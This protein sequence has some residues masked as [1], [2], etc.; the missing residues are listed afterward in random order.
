MTHVD[1]HHRIQQPPSW[2]M[3][4]LV[5]FSLA[6][7]AIGAYQ[8]WHYVKAPRGEGFR[9]LPLFA[10][11]AINALVGIAATVWAWSL[12]QGQG[13]S[14]EIP[15]LKLLILAVGGVL[16]LS[17]FVCLG[18]LYVGT[19]SFNDGPWSTLVLKGREAWKQWT[20]WQPVV[21]AVA[22]L[23]VMFMSLLAV[24]SEERTNATLRR[25]IYGY[26]AA[27]TG[28]L[29]L[30][31]L[32]V[33]CVMVHFYGVYKGKP[34]FDWTE[35]HIYSIS[36]DTRRLL[37]GVKNPVKI[38]I[39]FP[40]ESPTR[41]D[42]EML[43]SSFKRENPSRIEVESLSPTDLQDLEKLVALFQKY[44]IPFEDPSDRQIGGDGTN[45][46]VVVEVTDEATNK[47][48]HEFLKRMGQLEEINFPPPG[49]DREPVRLFKGEQAVVSAIANLN[50]ER[51][52]TVYLE[53]AG[54]PQQRS[55]V[56]DALRQA[57]G[58]SQ[59]EAQ[60]LVED[61]PAPVKENLSKEQAEEIENRLRLA[62]ASVSADDKPWIFFTQGNGEMELEDARSFVPPAF[63]FP[64][65]GLG[66]LR[67]RLERANYTVKGFS[68][69]AAVGA[70][71][72]VP[73]AA[74]AVVLAGPEDFNEAKVEALREY[75]KRPGAK[76]IVLLDVKLTSE[77]QLA[78]T[79]LERFLGEF[80][81]QVAN[82]VIF[83]LNVPDIEFV[84]H[85]HAGFGV[86]GDSAFLEPFVNKGRFTLYKAR[87]VR[88]TDSPQYTATTLI[89][90]TKPEGKP[91]GQWAEE[92]PRK[93]FADAQENRRALL[94]R[95]GAMLR[96]PKNQQAIPLAVTVRRRTDD[97]PNLDPHSR[98]KPKG[99][100]CMVVIGDATFVSNGV[101]R[102]QG[103]LAGPPIFFDLINGSLAW[104]R[105]RPDVITTIEPKTRKD[106]KMNAKP[107]QVEDL[108][109]YL[110]LALLAGIVAC[111]TG[112]FLMRRR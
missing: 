74:F 73:R 16:G 55:K 79:G 108:R 72:R 67:D 99:Q 4:A 93:F 106:Y 7:L 52:Y 48:R 62:G 107:E 11:A 30:A 28:L 17:T 27:L 15:H 64:N 65:V 18:V 109:W 95:V 8:G 3:P 86:L 49:S 87:S 69:E 81:V 37:R 75:M 84:H 38:T 22:G 77:L 61:L 19:D 34:I 63:E 98:L 43:L 101:L 54:P 24:R 104:L 1:R 57:T 111:G 100:P 83:N 56:L 39:V 50:T 2:I 76:M 60:K 21:F 66:V 42:L 36:P 29:L 112:V 97:P 102:P 20:A 59:E 12:S 6:M 94:D 91:Y 110:V 80:G 9:Y 51:L 26:N 13:K 88:P 68:L 23:L 40:E 92:S 90:T 35:G 33:L 82:D 10:W 96:E 103:R 85:C 31:I 41:K 47:T 25:L 32:V 70:K 45:K 71:P 44:K 78:S 105:E 89:E 58:L 53:D 5:V 46:G 14:Q